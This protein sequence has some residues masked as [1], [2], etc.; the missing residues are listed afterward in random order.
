V[1]VLKPNACGL[2]KLQ[3]EQEGLLAY[4]LPTLLRIEK[5]LNEVL[6][7]LTFAQPLAHRRG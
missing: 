7:K 2:D 3:C 4:F 1:L 5:S 6:S